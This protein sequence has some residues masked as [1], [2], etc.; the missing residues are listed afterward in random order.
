M[1][2]T[3]MKNLLYRLALP[4][5]APGVKGKMNHACQGQTVNC[6]KAYER[7]LE[8]HHVCGAS[9]LLC[10]GERQA[11]V[12]TS[13]REPDHP[14]DDRTMYRVASITKM[15][16]ALVTLML[17]EEGRFTLDTPVV[18]L[19]PAGDLPALRGVT[20]R[21]LL[22]H[23]SGLRD[24]LAL[25]KALWEGATYHAVLQSEGVRGGEPGGEM[26]YSNLGFGL[27]GM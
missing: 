18:E 20:V 24:T 14:A 16:T 8:K 10:D 6:L 2:T 26:S 5:L 19:L 25:D 22:C 3:P 13:C 17:C 7:V 9:L 11:L 4:F 1:P 12:H 23:T 27:L 21:H 15:A